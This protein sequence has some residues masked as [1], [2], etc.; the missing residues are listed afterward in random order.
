MNAAGRV[1]CKCGATLVLD[2]PRSR[3]PSSPDLHEADIVSLGYT[4]RSVAS[5]RAFESAHEALREGVGLGH[6]TATTPDP[7][8]A[9]R[10]ALLWPALGA[11][12]DP[13][14]FAPASVMMFGALLL[15][16]AIT[17]SLAPSPWA[18]LAAV[19]A[20]VVAAAGALA[21][22]S[23]A[24]AVALHQALVESNAG[25]A[26]AV[27]G[28]FLGPRRGLAVSTLRHAMMAALAGCACVLG[29]AV[30]LSLG[31]V[32]ETAAPWVGLTAP[33]QAL[34]IAGALAALLILVAVSMAHAA[35][36]PSSAGLYA[37]QIE[38]GARRVFGRGKN[39]LLRPFNVAVGAV[40]LVGLGLGGVLAVMLSVW[41]GLAAV[42]GGAASETSAWEAA[43]GRTVGW[44][45][46]ASLAAGVWT[47][48]IGVVGL[49]G[50]YALGIGVARSPVRAPEII[51][52]TLRAMQAVID[53]DIPADAPV[54]A[55]TSGRA[56]SPPPP[57]SGV[58][59]ES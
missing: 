57:D 48:F 8:R 6:P 1:H 10:P 13:R 47:A 36:A 50:G 7:G 33:L 27:L 41:D 22:G 52:G 28:G 45:M 44:A 56:A 2:P 16:A 20:A 43:V 59:D 26:W 38:S 55:S 31:R 23:A 11:A 58:D 5:P 46:L 14:L 9:A 18:S 42:F 35:V 39:M 29:T 21:L 53:S 54:G 3:M 49:L 17:A 12:L 4:I 40:G 19:L 15:P 25:R 37:V 32:S 51:T 30:L 34:L 24:A